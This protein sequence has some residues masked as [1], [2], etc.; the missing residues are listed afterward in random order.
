MGGEPFSILPIEIR[1]SKD[2]KS[3]DRLLGRRTNIVG[4][5]SQQQEVC[6][7]FRKLE[8]EA[9][10]SGLPTGMLAKLKL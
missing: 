7:I 1:P 9:A 6:Q 10:A 5:R 4:T 3:T 8:F 2:R